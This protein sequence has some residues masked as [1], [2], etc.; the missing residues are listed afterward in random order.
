[1]KKLYTEQQY[2][3]YEKFMDRIANA[4]DI[5]EGLFIDDELK[6]WLSD[7]KISQIAE[8]QMEKRL[9]EEF[10]RENN[11]NHECEII[12]FPRKNKEL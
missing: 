8:E 11:E 9:E 7:S 4:D 10:I 5:V 3:I 1:M 6:Q 12:E 2:R